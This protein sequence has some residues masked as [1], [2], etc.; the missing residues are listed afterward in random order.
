[1]N[2]ERGA[3]IVNVCETNVIADEIDLLIETERTL[4]QLF[5]HKVEEDDAEKYAGK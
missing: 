1:M 4:N 2:T 3:G 5:R